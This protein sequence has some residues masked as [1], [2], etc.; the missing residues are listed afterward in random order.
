M[1][2]AVFIPNPEKKQ[3]NFT[4][5]TPLGITIYTASEMENTWS[6]A[7]YYYSYIFGVFMLY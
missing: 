7:L 5:A 4:K 1:L 3:P 6:I 2:L